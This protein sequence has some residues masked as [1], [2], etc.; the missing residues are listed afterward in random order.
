MSLNV[1]T[2]FPYRKSYYL[3]H[4]I[5][6]FHEIKVNI[7]NAWMRITKGYCWP[8]I[9][10][11][12]FWIQ[13]ILPP[14]LRKLADDPIGGY[15]DTNK[16]GYDFSTPEKWH[17]WLYSI[18]DVIE[19]TQELNWDGQNQYEK[20][21]REIREEERFNRN[22]NITMTSTYTEEDK[23][24]IRKKYWDREIELE[25]QRHALQHDAFQQLIDNLENL[26]S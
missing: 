2:D 13:E 16:N 24:K 18:A 25:R 15:P 12:G 17:D 11:L 3:T 26:W 8:D 5:K 4:P 20:Q 19:S 14:M 9:Y 22:K 7:K 6:F 21:W 10:D 23:E 1:L